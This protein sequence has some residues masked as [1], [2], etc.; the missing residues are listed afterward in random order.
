ME[1]IQP[2]EAFDS[3]T[4]QRGHVDSHRTHDTATGDDSK[5][6][7]G[8][9]TMVH[10]LLDFAWRCTSVI[11]EVAPPCIM[12]LGSTCISDKS[13][14]MPPVPEWSSS[15]Q[16]KSAPPSGSSKSSP[17]SEFSASSD[18]STS[19]VGMSSL[20]QS[21][22]RGFVKTHRTLTPLSLP[23]PWWV[24]HHWHGLSTKVLSKLIGHLLHQCRHSDTF[25]NRPY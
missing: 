12:L 24:C 17:L 4:E 23:L 13:S 10:L 21:V 5:A 16:V 19:V 25:C 18:S 6:Y 22:N 15:P 3:E 20:A 7:Q 1:G 9:D 8:G 14:S 11:L 2:F